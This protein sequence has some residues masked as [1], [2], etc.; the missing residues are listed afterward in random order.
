M[1]ANLIAV[2]GEFSEAAS[3]ASDLNLNKC[4]SLSYK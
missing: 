3:M 4:F 2:N 1:Q